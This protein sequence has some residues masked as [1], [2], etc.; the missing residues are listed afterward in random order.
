MWGSLCLNRG[1]TSDVYGDVLLVTIWEPR[2]MWILQE[3]LVGSVNIG[4]QLEKLAG[5]GCLPVN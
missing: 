1:A 2:W 4:R 5:R 3:G